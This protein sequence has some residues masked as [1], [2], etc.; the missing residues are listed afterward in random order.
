[1]YKN[2]A[3]FSVA[4]ALF[5][6]CAFAEETE[7][8]QR[9]I[10]FNQAVVTIRIGDSLHYRN[11]DDVTH[12]LMVVGDSGKIL[13]K[14]LQKPAAVITNQFDE[15]GLFEVRCAIHPKMKMRVTVRP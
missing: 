1:M 10:R 8:V 13:D 5:A 2:I 12:H 14:G 6:A 3:L 15:A 7:I 11:R 4:A 9:G